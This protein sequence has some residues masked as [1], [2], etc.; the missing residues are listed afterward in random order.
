MNADGKETEKT[1]IK[2]RILSGFRDFRPEVMIP[3]ERM[4]E[5][6]KQVYRAYGFAPIDTPTLEYLDILLGK[7]GDESDKQMYRFTDNGGRE[8]G[9]R[10]DLTVPLARFVAQHSNDLGLPFKRYHIALVWRG[11]R[12]Q[13]GRYREFM[14]CDFDCIGSLH[15]S[16]DIET[17]LVIDDLL[18]SLGFDRFTIR[19]N[20]RQILNGILET[21]GLLDK[22]VAV[23]RSLDK[24]GK[25]DRTAVIE[26]ME[27]KAGASRTEAENILKL[28]DLN[29]SNQ[30]ILRDLEPMVRGNEVGETGLARLHA[31]VD[32]FEAAGANGA[33]IKIDVSIARGLAYYTGAVFETVLDDLP[34][35]GSVC[36]GGRYDDLAGVYTKQELPGIGAS[37]GLDRLLAAQEK[38][39]MI[40]EV[41]TPAQIFIPYFDKTGLHQYLKLAGDLRRAG[42]RVEVYPEAKKLGQQLKYADRRGFVVAIIQGRDEFEQGVCQVKDLRSGDQNEVV[43]DDLQVLVQHLNDL[44]SDE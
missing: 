20:S 11:E 13:F 30:Q 5:T 43:T 33:R 16:S 24:L 25:V 29:G 1:R 19:L 2:P 44:L 32:G 4:I 3:R 7:G 10:F 21:V 40:P 9:M 14:Q 17:A 22:S 27:E 38:L 6:A 35:I 39:G 41:Q 23:L 28:A 8:V 34:G 26:E 18:H 12:Q 36:S 15:V 37:L 42:L 31:I